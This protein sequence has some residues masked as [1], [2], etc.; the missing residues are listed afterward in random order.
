MLSPT[1]FNF[2]HD[3]NCYGSILLGRFMQI[4]KTFWNLK[5]FTSGPSAL[6]VLLRDGLLRQFVHEAPLL[7]AQRPRVCLDLT[8]QSVSVPVVRSR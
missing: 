7:S 8:H 3:S 6:T 2:F 5:K 4:K 1:N